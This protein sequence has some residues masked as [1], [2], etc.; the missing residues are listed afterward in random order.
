MDNNSEALWLMLFNDPLN[1]IGK[2][3]I[4]L[5]DSDTYQVDSWSK[6]S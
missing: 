1:F 4:L 2:E 5:F 3:I 6:F